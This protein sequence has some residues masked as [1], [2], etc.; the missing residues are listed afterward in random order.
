MKLQVAMKENG[1]TIDNISD[2]A[3]LTYETARRYVKGK[4]CPSPAAATLIAS[5]F[6]W[7]IKEVNAMLLRDGERVKHGDLLDVAHGVDPLTQRLLRGFAVLSKEQQNM[8]L[9]MI[10]RLLAKK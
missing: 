1:L 9:E 5:H 3:G 2:I 7:D 10:N 6:K 4:T 8:I